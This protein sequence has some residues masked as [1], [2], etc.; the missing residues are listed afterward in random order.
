V[1]SP[2]GKYA[3]G[4][5]AL[6]S[7][8]AIGGAIALHAVGQADPFVDSIALLAVGA[9]FGASAAVN[10]TKE[11]LRVAQVLAEDAAKRLD[12]LGAAPTPLR[13]YEQDHNGQRI[14]PDE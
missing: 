11:P 13:R 6:V 2:L 9:I 1:N 12:A 8:M 5:A 3:Q 14:T 7:I 4:I 10:G